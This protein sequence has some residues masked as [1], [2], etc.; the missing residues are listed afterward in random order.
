MP[1]S[2]FDSRR[3]RLV[4]HVTATALV[5]V[6]SA[7]SLGPNST[8][9]AGPVEANEAEWRELATVRVAPLTGAVRVSVGEIGLLDDNPWGLD[10]SLG[11][12]VGL[13][14]LVAVGLLRRPDVRFVERRRFA[15]AADAERR[16]EP[17]G[18]GAPPVGVSPGPEFILSATW[19]L[20]GAA[21]AY[22]E[23]RL[24][25]P[26]S[27]RVERTWRT[28]TPRDADAVGV[29]RV[30]VGGLVAELGRM[31]RAPAWS[32]PFAHAAPT[33]FEPTNISV[34]A[35]NAFLAGLAS[36]EVWNWESA[37]VGYQAATTLDPN[38]FEAD[39][40]LA[41][42]ARLRSGGTLGSS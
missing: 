21:T 28:E 2:R 31:G 39:V 9:T 6:A 33:T 16:G 24:I 41:R 15:A 1:A 42:T 19:A 12:S 38:F 8:S 22:L 11:A 4:R 29:A 14:E 23:G 37:R 36:E 20:F 10:T 35:V 13:S 18:P 40:A 27:G 7:C 30:I 17:R 34:S 5:L 25:N 32:D 3:P 26:A